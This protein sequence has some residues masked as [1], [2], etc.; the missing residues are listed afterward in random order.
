MKKI[1]MI[2]TICLLTFNIN[3]TTRDSIPDKVEQAISDSTQLSVKQVYNDIKA[4]LTGLAGALKVGSE[5]VYE[6]L[7][8]QQYVSSIVNICILI[9]G[10]ILLL[11]S[12]KTWKW[13]IKHLKES[14]WYSIFPPTIITILSIGCI[15]GQINH[16]DTTI[17]GFINP[18]YGAMMQIKDFIK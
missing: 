10:I 12:L 1:I 4:G 3:A 17:T 13:G 7:C 9:V 11:I 6:V 5:H 16:F 18:E 8:K 14:D 15:G 2:M